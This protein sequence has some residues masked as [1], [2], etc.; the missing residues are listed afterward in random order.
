MAPTS[1]SLGAAFTPGQATQAV[2]AILLLAC[3]VLCCRA[4]LAENT[5]VTLRYA[6]SREVAN[7][8]SGLVAP[9]GS[10]NVYQSQI[11]IQAG[12]QNTAELIRIIEFLD[13]PPRNLLISV[14]VPSQS[15]TRNSG[16]KVS[17][18][19]H[20]PEIGSNTRH[21]GVGDSRGTTTET[22]VRLRSYS[23]GITAGAGSAQSIRALEGRDAFIQVASTVSSP[24]WVASRQ[25]FYVNARVHGQQ[26]SLSLHGNNDSVAE[27]Q[28]NTSAMVTRVNGRLGEWLA[29]GGVS[30]AGQHHSRSLNSA[31]R[32]SHSSASAVYI[33]VERLD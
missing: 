8:L 25:G 28:A 9:G 29:V 11:I 6:E 4:A 26:V 12:P 33:K 2:A 7:A 24:Q 27:G 19:N 30:G 1:H 3:S 16:I 32:N 31:N 15:V 10:V 14:K 22:T 5:I 20:R 18:G 13:Q 21:Y 17:R 23:R